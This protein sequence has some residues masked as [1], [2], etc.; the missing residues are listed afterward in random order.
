M[1]QSYYSIFDFFT[2]DL[3]VEDCLPSNS[4]LYEDGPDKDVISLPSN[5]GFKPNVNQ[6]A[7]PCSKSKGILKCTGRRKFFSLAYQIPS[8]T[9]AIL[10]SYQ[11]TS[12][13]SALSEPVLPMDI[14]EGTNYAPAY[15]L[16]P[17]T[18]TV[19]LDT[20]E[21]SNQKHFINYQVTCENKSTNVKCKRDV[22]HSHKSTRVTD[23]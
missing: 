16:K 13:T 6:K 18:S 12:S 7:T 2:K 10:K 15:D 22:E 9:P 1:H 14:S 17:A 21:R 11:R 20:N 19:S 5:S 4:L 8:A 23:F 3:P